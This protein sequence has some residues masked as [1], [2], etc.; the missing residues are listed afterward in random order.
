MVQ[1][2]IRYLSGEEAPLMAGGGPYVFPIHLREGAREVI[3]V[4]NLCPDSVRPVIHMDGK[5]KW[6]GVVIAPLCAP[7]RVELG[8]TIEGAGL[9]AETAVPYLGCVLLKKT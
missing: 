9:C 8:A 3:V 6:S 2:L 7:E 1:N 4:L 5:D